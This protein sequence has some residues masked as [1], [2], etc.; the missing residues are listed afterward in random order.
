MAHKQGL[1]QALLVCEL[2]TPSAV[3][4]PD[5]LQTLLLPFSIS[6]GLYLFL[7]Y[8]LVPFWRSQSANLP[9]DTMNDLA[10]RARTKVVGWVSKIRRNRD[11]EW[12]EDAGEE[13]EE[14]MLNYDVERARVWRGR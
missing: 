4:V 1:P 12:D 7:S 8:I 10:S 13:E 11:D 6:L 2:L 14:G 3:L 5:I 9:L